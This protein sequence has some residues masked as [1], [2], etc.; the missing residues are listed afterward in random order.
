MITLFDPVSIEKHHLLLAKH[1][2]EGKLWKNA[3]D[4]DDDFGKLFLGLC[5]EFLRFQ[6]LTDTV[7]DEMDINQTDQLLID[8]EKSVGLP[9]S[10]FNTNKSNEERRKQ[11]LQK[12]SKFEGVQSKEGEQS[13]TDRRR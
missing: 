7:F 6:V 5:I 1:L 3:F 9:D 13:S 4:P 8:W 2:P 11:V 10:C 12:F